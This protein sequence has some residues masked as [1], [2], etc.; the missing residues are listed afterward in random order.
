MDEIGDWRPE[1]YGA[2]KQVRIDSADSIRVTVA[3]LAILLGATC[4]NETVSFAQDVPSQT[5]PATQPQTQPGPPTSQPQRPAEATPLP[6]PQPEPK[7]RVS[8]AAIR[9]AMRIN[10]NQ[11]FRELMQGDVDLN[12]PLPDGQTLLRYA[13]QTNRPR[14]AVMLVEKGAPTDLINPIDGETYIYTAAR[15]GQVDVI[16][17]LLTHHVE[18]DSPNPDSGRSALYAAVF[19]KKPDAAKALLELGADPD[20]KDLINQESPRSVA[21]E[22]DNSEIKHILATWPAKDRAPKP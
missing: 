18:I 22:S 14:Q 15:Y 6:Q 20:R 10:D 9:D 8:G 4:F 1:S 3:G 21:Q 19:Y 16:K 12:E 5:Q 17:A 2:Q 13:I 11:R 7:V